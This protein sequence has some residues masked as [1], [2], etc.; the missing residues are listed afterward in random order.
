MQAHTRYQSSLN[1]KKMKTVELS[2]QEKRKKE[3]HDG[4]FSHQ[5]RRRK[6]LRN[7]FRNLSKRPIPLPPRL[8]KK[9]ELIC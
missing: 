7:V 1:K 3:V 8:R 4:S 5:E 6:D 9:T 2:Q